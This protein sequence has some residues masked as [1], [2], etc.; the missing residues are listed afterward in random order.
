MI[1]SCPSSVSLTFRVAVL[2][3][4]FIFG[5]ANMGQITTKNMIVQYSLQT[6]VKASNAI[7]QR[8]GL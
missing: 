3:Y 1:D 2:F 8:V 5:N 7:E 6:A 4:S